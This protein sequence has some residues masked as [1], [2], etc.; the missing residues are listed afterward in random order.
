MT[1]EGLIGYEALIE[2]HKEHHKIED[3]LIAERDGLKA[4]Y[5]ILEAGWQDIRKQRNSLQDEIVAL[6]ANLKVHGD[7]EN[8]LIAERD[9]LLAKVK[10]A[11]PAIELAIADI[12]ERKRY[13]EHESLFTKDIDPEL[14][15]SYNYWIAK[16]NE[17]I[18]ILEGLKEEKEK[19]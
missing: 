1:T 2:H 3:A 4:K 11:Q 14:Y 17:A 9:A 18:A 12:K 10:V 8:A 19:E 7:V 5:N 6:K 16:R 13:Y 15:Q